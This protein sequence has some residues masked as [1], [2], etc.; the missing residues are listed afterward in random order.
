MNQNTYAT[1]GLGADE[2]PVDEERPISGRTAL[3][4]G[5]LF[6]LWVFSAAESAPILC[7]FLG[8]AAAVAGFSCRE[9]GLRPRFGLQALFVLAYVLLS[10]V[11]CFYAASGTLALDDFLRLLP[12]FFV[13]LLLLLFS[14][15]GTSRGRNGAAAISIVTALISFLSID[16]AG[17]RWFSGGFQRLTGHFTQDYSIFAGLEPGTRI[18]SIL[19]D[20]NVFAGVA[21]LGVLLGLS[22]A[23]SAEGRRERMLHLCCLA[24]NA[25][26]F[27]LV[28]SLGAAG[29]I[30]VAFA[31]FLL[32]QR[33][34]TRLAAAV[35]M[36]E[37]LVVTMLGAAAVY[38]AVFDGTKDFS[39]VP[40]LACV[41]CAALLCGADRL[42]AARVTEVLS[43]HPRAL[44]VAT[45]ALVLALAAYAAAA[46]NV[47]GPAALAPGETLARAADLPAGAYT[48]AVEADG[49]AQVQIVSKNEKNLIM[50]TESVLYEGDISGIAFTVPE[51]SEIVWFRFFAPE[52][53]TISSAVYSGDGEGALKLGYRL[54]PGFIANRL[55]GLWANQNAV[56]RAQFWRD[57]LKLWRQHPIFGDGLGSMETGLYSVS[58]FHYES[59]YVHNH[60]VQAMMDTGL[61]GLACFVGM[62]CASGRLLWL[63][64]KRETVSPLLSAL[65]AALVFMALQA[66][67]QVDFSTHSFLPFAFGVFA[68]INVAGTELSAPVF[69]PI[70]APAARRGKGKKAAVSKPGSAE[71][72][73]EALETKEEAPWRGKAR[74]GLRW[75]YPVL[76]VLCTLIL[77]LHFYTQ[78]H[79]FSGSGDGYQRLARAAVT[80]PLYRVNYWQTYLY[81]GMNS[82]S[83]QAR[84]SLPKYAEK[85]TKER[86]NCD[87]NYAVEYYFY[88]GETEAAVDALLDHLAYNRVRSDAWQYAFDLLLDHYDGSDEYQAQAL[89]VAEAMDAWNAQAMEQVE[90]TPT[91]LTYLATLR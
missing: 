17:T 34:G 4:A 19:E 91:N 27:V 42:A 51:D 59:K 35:V 86:M 53:V 24:L 30:A 3:W 18:T 72:V 29:F 9:L 11:S 33:K 61:V 67:M 77:S 78:W 49:K 90:L 74:V 56:Q 36:V 32:F 50:H 7:F 88:A 58:D 80:D 8:I 84:Q 25:L 40:L 83:A 6:L 46:F 76:G 14:G 44:P 73:P 15:R 69:K 81:H 79:V 16:A 38:L 89:R 52:G 22:L 5:G 10:G 75:A 82:D 57:G 62:L 13:Y 39:V 31:A 21:G 65:G 2:R 54:L 12:G 68:L 20:P 45:A 43:R 48:C 71:D 85:L 64:R 70:S 47:T 28:F 66:V 55:Q 60:Y 63:G 87:P 41:G 26:G 37:T 23:L 1:L